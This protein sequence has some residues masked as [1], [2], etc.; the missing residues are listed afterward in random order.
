M[1]PSP[2]TTS[3]RGWE[4]RVVVLFWLACVVFGFLQAWASRFTIAND[5]I[6]FLDEGEACLRGEWKMAIN[7]Y[8]FPLWGLLL[9]GTLRAV[10]PSPYWE[11]FVVHM[12]AFAVF[13]FSAGCF[14]FFLAALL[15][16]RSAL[17]LRRGGQ[18]AWGAWV[19]RTIA[20]ALFLWGSLALI[21]ADETNP[22]ML[23]AAL[24]YLAAGILL[25]IREGWNGP[26]AFLALGAVL[27]AAYLTKAAM[28]P[29]A[30]VTLAV[31]GFAGRTGRRSALKAL[32][33]FAAFALLSGP[34][35]LALSRDRG[36]LDWGDS[37][38][39]AYEWI[40]N[41]APSR[42]WQGR[43]AENGRPLHPTR[44][45]LARPALY[46][47][48]RSGG[49]TYPLWYDVSYWYEGFR[50]HFRPRRQLAALAKNVSDLLDIFLGLNG[51]LAVGVLLLIGVC[52]EPSSLAHD[53][54][55][56]GFGVLLVPVAAALCLYALVSVISRY[57]AP[58]VVL[59]AASVLFAVR[60]PDSTAARRFGPAL[61]LLL[62]VMVL[63]PVGPGA[64]P[65]YYSSAISLFRP[66]TGHENVF[67][68]VARALL[69]RGLSP[70]DRVAVLEYGNIDHVHWAR[71]GRLRITT[72]I[73]WK[74][75]HPVDAN[76]Y[77]K[78]DEAGRDR[79]L[80]V[81][82]STGVRVLVS[83]REP[84]RDHA[85]GWARID[86]TGYYV[87]ELVRRS[88]AMS[89]SEVRHPREETTRLGGEDAPLEMP[90][91]KR[92]SLF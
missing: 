21:G 34:F 63:S 8:Y 68:N 50:V 91:S 43:P 81:F 17:A 60:V 51:A 72:E 1:M 84:P 77:W 19:W 86:D 28:F 59:L 20:Y 76:D 33:G 74:A 5:C 9:A 25:R 2:S 38:R 87:H 54:A 15:R 65:K 61:A 92:V 58:F 31:A 70:G 37:G 40:V 30:L 66:S 32:L 10:K 13:L 11:Y 75:D 73:Y 71:L 55:D 3:G 39:L 78:L 36:R 22:D 27:A 26:L 35:V 29:V 79:V 6:S 14:E 83:D 89:E 4:R 7:G 23:V 46:E 80:E 49:A 48:D 16:H 67:W 24:M 42:H 47:F 12:A 57:V 90:E 45:L 53:L 44:Q 18:V 56:S 85:S 52:G 88:A 64:F 41:G 69:S 62:A 82:A